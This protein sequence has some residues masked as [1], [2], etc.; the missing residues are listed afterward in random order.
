MFSL[1]N[2]LPCTND[3]QIIGHN[4]A[5]VKT[6]PFPIQY[7]SNGQSTEARAGTAGAH[8]ERTDPPLVRS[9]CRQHHVQGSCLR[10][11]QLLAADP[12]RD[13]RHPCWR[14]ALTSWCR[15]ARQRRRPQARPLRPP[16]SPR[17]VRPAP[18]APRGHRPTPR[19]RPRSRPGR[20]RR[21]PRA[22]PRH[23]PRPTLVS[24]RPGPADRRGAP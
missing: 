1:I 8:V 9:V 7:A 21:C 13:G 24:P 2:A 14:A 22:P 5:D 19:L 11:W 16:L 23:C 18:R 15:R 10:E 3:S 4:S 17:T 6:V 20:P 12:A